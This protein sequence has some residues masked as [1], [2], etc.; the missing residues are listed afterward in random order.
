MQI[1]ISCNIDKNTFVKVKHIFKL[2]VQEASNMYSFVR[3][4]TPFI[5][6][7]WLPMEA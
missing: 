2:I 1:S 6:F 5:L 7:P 3:L 4:W